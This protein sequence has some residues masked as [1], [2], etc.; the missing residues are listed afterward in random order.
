MCTARHRASRPERQASSR[1]AAAV[2]KHTHNF[3][4]SGTIADPMLY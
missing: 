2:A 3:G 1:T 4:Y